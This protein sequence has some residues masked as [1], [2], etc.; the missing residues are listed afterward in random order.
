[1]AFPCP[2]AMSCTLETFSVDQSQLLST[3]AESLFQAPV[4]EVHVK[5][6]ALAKPGKHT[7]FRF[8]AYPSDLFNKIDNMQVLIQ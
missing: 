7:P 3:K 1:M 5:N 6:T 4:S 8:A 2:P